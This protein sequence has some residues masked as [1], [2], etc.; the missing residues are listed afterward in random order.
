MA[1][2]VIDVGLG[3]T[4]TMS[5]KLA[6]EQLGFGPC[7]HMEEVLKAPDQA[8]Q[9]LA[10]ADDNPVDWDAVFNGY[11]AAVDWPTARFWRAII[12]QYPDAKII[13]TT[14]DPNSWF[15][16][17][18]GTIHLVLEGREKIGNPVMRQV[19]DMAHRI[20]SDQTFAGRLGEAA[21]ATEVFRRH[22]AAVI[23]AVP[24]DRLLVFEVAQGWGPLCDYLGCPAP[25]TPF[26]R[27]NS[28][29]EFWELVEQA[30]G[31]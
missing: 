15:K 13:L 26:P 20:I 31:G 29:K 6:L 21:H 25:D 17:I 23:E 2:D 5:L 24:P 16:S 1:L 7:H 9:W 18:S 8:Q 3:R 10:A 12:D 11:R 19:M 14:R 28:T 4:G 22:N 30:S 27:V